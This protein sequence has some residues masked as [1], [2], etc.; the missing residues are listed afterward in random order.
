[1][2]L[3]PGSIIRVFFFLLISVAAL[4]Q[5][6]S[7]LHW[8]FSQNNNAIFFDQNTLQPRLESIP[9][10]LNIGQSGVA[11]D[12]VTGELIFYTDGQQVYDKFHRMVTNGAGLLANPAGPQAVALSAVPGIDNQ[13]Q[14]Y[15]FTNSATLAAAGSISYSVYDTALYGAGGFPAPAAGDIDPAR[16]NQS[17]AGLT[18]GTLS[19]AM[20]VVS[21]A[22]FDGFWLITHRRNS[23]DYQVTEIMNDGSIG[24][25]STYTIPGAPLIAHT[26][27]HT[28]STRLFAAG[29]LTLSIAP[30]DD[31]PVTLVSFDPQTGAIDGAN[32]QFIPNTSASQLANQ[33]IFDTEF[34][35]SGK[36][37]YISGNFNSAADSLM[38][39][40]LEDPTL[41]P[42][43]LTTAR[44]MTRS[45][46]IQRGPDD[47]IYHL[48]ENTN[49]RL[50]RIND[51]D[52]VAADAFYSRTAIGNTVFESQQFAAFLPLIEPQL[53]LDF[54]IAGNCANTPII[55]LPSIKPAADS[56]IWDFGDGE[57]SNAWSPRHTYSQAG[58]FNVRLIAF[59]NGFAQDT[60]KQLTLQEFDLEITGVPQD[61]VVCPEDFPLE[62][63]AE[64]EGQAT[65]QWSNQTTEGP[66]TSID[67]A[68]NYY[69]VATAPNG[70]STYA[71][72]RVQEY[73]AE[74]QRAFIWY[75]GE[76]AG[77]D[78]NPIVN[79]GAPE[80]IPYGDPTI[81]NGGNEMVAPEG[82][83]IYNDPNGSP[84]LYSNGASVYDREG[85]LVATLSGDPGATQS[86]MIME[87]PG[88][89]SLYYIFT[90]QE[91]YDIS[92]S[93]SYE[94]HYSIF[95][96]KLRN[97]LGDII[98]DQNGVPVEEVLMYN[99]TER[100]TGNQQW[101]IAHEYGNN[102]FRAYR[103][104]ADG[105]QT[106]VISQI[107][108]AHPT[109]TESAAHGY[110]RL[111]N[112]NTLAV[113]LPLNGTNYIEVFDFIDSTGV[114][115][116]FRQIDVGNDFNVDGS[117]YGL[118]FSTSGRKIF[119]S[120]HGGSESYIVEYWLDSLNNPVP[121][122]GQPFTSNLT[123]GALQVGPDGSIY[124]AA[125][126]QPFLGSI[127]ASPDTTQASQFQEQG[128]AL[129]PGTNSLL[130]LP[131]FI[132]QY[133]SSSTGASITGSNGGCPGEDI[134]FE[135]TGTSTFDTYT[136]N[137][138][139]LSDN[140]VVDG[141]VIEGPASTS[142]YTFS[143]DE[144]GNYEATV[145][146]T[147]QCSNSMDTLLRMPFT[148]FE[149]PAM[150]LASI[151]AGACSANDGQLDVTMNFTGTYHYTIRN[152]DGQILDA[153]FDVDDPSLSLDSLSSGAYT[154]FV[155]EQ[156]NGCSNSENIT[157]NED[158]A[159][160]IDD[161]NTGNSDCE[162]ENGS[163][164]FS[165]DANAVPPVNYRIFDQS[166]NNQVTSGNTNASDTTIGNIPSGTY[167]LELVDQNN[168]SAF[169]NDLTIQ[170][171][172]T[173]TLETDLFVAACD[174]STYR[175][176]AR[177]PD[178]AEIVWTWD[179]NTFTGDSID[180]E[181]PGTYTVTARGDDINTCDNTKTVN[182]VFSTADPNPFREQYTICPEDPIEANN[183]VR[184]FPGSRFI[185]SQFFTE[186]GTRIDEN[187]PGF[188]FAGD[189]L[190]VYTLANIRAELTNSAGCITEAEIA[191]IET[192]EA[193]ITVPNAF[194]P[195]S[196]NETNT[197]F[198]IYSRFIDEDN[199]Q[200][201]IFNRWGEIV[202]ESDD[203]QFRWNGGKLNNL[204]EPVPQGTYAY[205]IRYISSFQPQLGEQVERGGVV[206]LR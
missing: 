63:T 171:P 88:D 18:G 152:T 90:T 129:A 118:E 4:G 112:R 33:N 111:S 31:R 197:A 58:A 65:F 96:I 124:V 126:N 93:S 180:V 203:P 186:D 168:C 27:S 188:E 5:K 142:S 143:T 159:F 44:N 74:E 97:G 109:S 42:V 204:N 66:E 136:W 62:L 134:L 161:F 125:D 145:F 94:L 49:F 6:N 115:S 32:A 102:I 182:V 162:G 205:V 140:S 156:T 103:L 55:F 79:G 71:P 151:D 117:I 179:N 14:Y 19:P 38:Q 7:Q 53:E 173:A 154:V 1:M 48:Y 187:T 60:S 153:G 64:A 164:F 26:I 114:V 144:P 91:V 52:S 12:P 51:P 40:D 177:T 147:N 28:D 157:I 189:T 56:V 178:G 68:G 87:Y 116:N 113:A 104:T 150:T 169:L 16:K 202:F 158:Q 199:F 131:N 34:S 61:T 29:Q 198:N 2:K 101:L 72:T 135:A 43:A 194:R 75:F 85:N 83:A 206:V 35:P 70:C 155:I 172:D 24:A 174:V 160:E 92:G 76:H 130:G 148:V 110:M 149:P 107:G 73:G 46:G 81:Y 137:I 138:I 165:V 120:L 195:Q 132:S 123:L 36:Y 183:V 22:A 21:N 10:T 184:L 45:Y 20:V 192:C 30:Q 13:G 167:Y 196:A 201:I 190:L 121:Q 95:D 106:P 139:R 200:V 82:C 3:T 23:E 89:A 41:T 128:F 8:Y 170:R 166:N 69:V 105:I 84:I 176:G 39:V 191:I 119:G 133:G 59:S 127:N 99:S 57:F 175:I 50:G 11:S 108:S 181:R 100:L 15:I 141:P 185:Q 80:A 122:P 25:T 146:I 78:F 17:V 86:V 37:L 9:N 54:E 67:S 77:I 47:R 98:K 193:R 163:I